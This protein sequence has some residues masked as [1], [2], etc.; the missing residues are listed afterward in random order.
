VWEGGV[1]KKWG[2]LDAA[3]LRGL[4][5]ER[6]GFDARTTESQVEDIGREGFPCLV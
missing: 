3:G 4:R 5:H 2:R 6:N 1:E